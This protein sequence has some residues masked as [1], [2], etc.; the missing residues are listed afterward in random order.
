M[1]EEHIALI[2]PT[3]ELEASFLA[4]AAEYAAA[5]ED[6]HQNVRGGQFSAYVQR[7]ADGARGVGLPD[8]YVP[9]STFWLVRAGWEILGVSRLRHRLSDHL[10]VTGGHVGYDIRPSERR[11]GY[12]TR[13]LAL[14]LEKARARGL[15]RLLVTCL[16]DNVGSAQIIEK[17]GGV[18]QD[19]I[20]SK[21]MGGPLKRY[22][23]DL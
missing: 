1:A 19:V 10:L 3:P 17:S 4:M 5:G 22:W 12:G 14:T 6:Y 16:A 18:L 2:D 20:D 21:D 23:I 9:W 7:L 15:K 13:I 11:K 8:G